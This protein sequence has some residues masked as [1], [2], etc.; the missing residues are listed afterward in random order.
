MLKNIQIRT[1]HGHVL[2]G[3]SMHLV[4]AVCMGTGA[5]GARPSALHHERVPEPHAR[6]VDAGPNLAAPLVEGD[7]HNDDEAPPPVLPISSNHT[8]EATVLPRKRSLA[9]R[10]LN[11]LQ[12]H[13]YLARPRPWRAHRARCFP[14]A[15]A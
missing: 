4:A 7:G 15:G 5:Y 13:M 9:R 11:A 1:L 2:P 14:A 12:W 6:I 10:A 8:A 3:G